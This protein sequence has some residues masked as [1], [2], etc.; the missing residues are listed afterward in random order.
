MEVE[1]GN[2]PLPSVG[3][4]LKQA[5][6]FFKKY[7]DG[8]VILAFVPWI[9]GLVFGLFWVVV[10]VVG[11]IVEG[12]RVS[13][14]MWSQADFW[15]ALSQQVPGLVWFGIIWLMVLVLGVIYAMAWGSAAM[16]RFLEEPENGFMRAIKQARGRVLPLIVYGLVSTIVIVIGYLL[17]I[18]PGVLFTIWFG[19]GMYIVV[20][21]NQGPIAAL[22]LSKKYVKKDVWWYIGKV[23]AWAVLYIVVMMVVEMVFDQVAPV[24]MFVVGILGQIY[25]YLVYKSLRLKVS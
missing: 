18:V 11:L 16:L 20:L 4:L 22:G 19:L 1:V 13:W 8:L 21:E 24:I 15:Q 10:G 5:W 14:G 9:M 6:E 7:W 25:G 23:L 17:L 3:S 12:V 2:Q